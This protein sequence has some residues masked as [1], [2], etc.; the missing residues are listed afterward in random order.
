MSTLKADRKWGNYFTN[1]RLETIVTDTFHIWERSLLHMASSFKHQCC[2]LCAT[3]HTAL[4]REL[5]PASLSQMC[6]ALCVRVKQH[7]LLHATLF[8]MD[9]HR[10]HVKLSTKS[11]GLLS[12]SFCVSPGQISPPN[13]MNYVPLRYWEGENVCHFFILHSSVGKSFCMKFSK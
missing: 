1:I 5:P 11:Q 4:E 13:M 12:Y 8:S 7:R 6:V 9:S 10:S 3:Q 2:L